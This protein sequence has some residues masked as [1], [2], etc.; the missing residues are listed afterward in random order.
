MKKDL[1]YSIF[2]IENKKVIEVEKRS[3]VL[4]GKEEEEENPGKREDTLDD[5]VKAL[6]DDEPRF[7]L[8]DYHFDSEDGRPQE[9]MTFVFWSPDEGAKVKDKMLYASSKDAIKKKFTGISKEVQATSVEDLDVVEVNK[10]ML[11]K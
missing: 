2:K 7:A 3:T 8:M 5:F 6:P 11:A 10:K 1:R 9:K 4:G